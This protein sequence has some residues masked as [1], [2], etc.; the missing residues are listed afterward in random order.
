M[1]DQ[2]TDSRTVRPRGVRAVL[3]ATVVLVGTLAVAGGGPVAPGA[4]A[5]DG[6]A[7]AAAETPSPTPADNE[8]AFG[9]ADEVYVTEEGDAILV[10]EEESD[11]NATS[12][13]MGADVSA[14]LARLLVVGESD[15][16]LEEVDGNLST[17][18][19]PDRI[20]T[21]GNLIAERPAELESLDA[22]ASG[23]VNNQTNQMEATVDATFVDEESTSGA[24]MSMTTEGSMTQT[25]TTFSTSGSHAVS[26]DYEGSV[27]REPTEF[28]FTLVENDDTYE[29][30]VT[31]KDL[32][33]SRYGGERWNTSEAARETLEQQYVSAAEEWGGTAEIT[34]HEYD[35]VEREDDR[36]RLTI[37]YSVV[38]RGI[39][40]GLEQ[41]L[42]DDLATDQEMDMSR[43]QARSVAEGVTDADV[44]RIEFARSRGPNGMETSWDVE[45]TG[46]DAVL[47]ALVDAGEQGAFDT[48]ETAVD[49]EDFEDARSMLEA[50]E[51]ADLR[52]TAEWRANVERTAD[53]ETTVHAEFSESA[54]NWAAYVEELEARGVDRQADT[55]FDVR[56]YDEG[57]E[58]HVEG[59]FEVVNE[60]LVSEALSSSQE[61]LEDSSTDEE[62]REFLA[63]LEESDFE[64]ARIDVDLS[65]DQMTVEASAKAENM[66][67]F[68]PEDAAVS[69]DQV[70]VRGDGDQ[71][72]TYVFVSDVVE[73]GSD[74][75]REDLSHV[76]AVTEETTVHA[77]GEWNRS[78]PE[79]DAR[80]AADHLGVEYETPDPEGD[81]GV[82]TPG[83]GALTAA[84]ALALAVLV[85]RRRHR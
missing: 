72:T 39:D 46:Y 78:F 15:E 63:A 71:Q 42:A 66:S 54:E 18:V 32:V 4:G 1:S 58:V 9:D 45:I 41:E 60:G 44:E 75:T 65:G 74:V 59:E 14:G 57:E 5:A 7:V 69:P 73:D 19:E 21:D 11:S 43:E 56:A 79:F 29:I 68:V 53:G 20:A 80:A 36:D 28:A 40:D 77:A 70:V 84:L 13:E 33:Y 24:A 47:Y 52:T 25:A 2:R 31:R 34:I 64:V 10:Y 61:D 85:A 62:T 55:T 8:T 50:R 22:E 48:E 35:Y 37:R 38:Y 17:F 6:P 27:D 3:L 16:D 82:M 30:D 81:E 23:T 26:Y 67:A 83:F 76:D 51:A 12:V 49:V